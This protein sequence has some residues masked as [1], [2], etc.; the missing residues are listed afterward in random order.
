MQGDG[1][2]L[3]DTS[4]DA[5]RNAIL[6]HAIS[7]F[8]A[9]G[10]FD[11]RLEDVASRL[12]TAK[13]SISYHF[14][15]KQSL[16]FEAYSAN[17]DFAEDAIAG[18]LAEQTGLQQV[19]KWL[20]L[21]AQAQ[22]ASIT[23]TGPPLAMLNDVSALA[24]DDREQVATRMSACADAICGMIERGNGDGSVDL[25]SPQLSAFFLLNAP[26]WIKAWLDAL[27][28]RH[29]GEAIERLLD[30]LSHGIVN[31]RSA[32]LN[33]S[34][35]EVRGDEIDM[36]FNR[37]TRKQMQKSAF[38]RVGT[39]HFNLQGYANVSL[40]DVAGELGVSRGALYYLFKDKDALLNACADRTLELFE[41]NLADAVNDAGS[42]AASLHVAAARLYA[43][44]LNNLDPLLRP[45]MFPSLT[46][47][48][49]SLAKARF[50][51]VRSR[52]DELYAMG[53]R[54][55]SI[56]AA[57]LDQFGV[58]LSGAILAATRQRLE[59]FG[60]DTSSQGSLAASPAGFF[61]MLFKGAASR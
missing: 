29:H 52:C 21:V 57:G 58:I 40:N 20:K 39:R 10:F 51:R 1:F 34:F 31:D 8:N 4:R 38:V 30:V 18:A 59:S 16:L 5:K 2:N 41:R 46:E 53:M 19:Q 60:I 6:S 3:Q 28:P 14:K 54:E 55:G 36:L 24:D 49:R 48:E 23:G 37:N 9:R 12:D 11:T 61:E 35:A 50:A 33:I 47:A 22:S 17:C 25:R 45:V 26:Q 15:S 13:T 43:G 32:R 7:L 44:H 42:I 27:A 56:R